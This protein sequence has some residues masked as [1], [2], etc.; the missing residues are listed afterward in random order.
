MEHNQD[1]IELIYRYIRDELTAEEQVRLQQWVNGSATNRQFFTEV[2]QPGKLFSES[3]MR[4][5]L[6]ER[7]QL[8][9]AWQKLL[10]KGLPA[11]TITTA[12]YGRK[13]K[14]FRIRF[15]LYAV[16][17]SVALFILAGVYLY[18]RPVH[19]AV[20]QTTTRPQHDVAPN[21]NQPML[22]LADG[23]VVPL[24]SNSSGTL[25][26]QGN[27][28][29][30][31]NANGDIIYS[32]ANANNPQ[33][34]EAFNSISVPKGGNVVSL[35]LADGTKVW[36]N[37]ASSIRY[38]T[39]FSGEERKV[40]MTGEAYF[41]VAHVALQKKAMPFVVQKG[42]MQVTVLGT[43][44]NVNSYDDE[45][46][47]KVTLLEGKVKVDQS[48]P[49]K[50]GGAGNQSAILKPGEQAVVTADARLTVHDN[51]DMESVMAWKNGLFV[52]DNSSTEAIMRQVQRWYNVNVVYQGD[53][54]HWTFNGQISRYSNVSKVLDLMEA[55]GTVHFK[56]EDRTIYV[57]P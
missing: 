29:I 31:R 43:H 37:A 27:V 9:Q 12:P 4:E 57:T 36:L 41:E 10:A 13:A 47:L 56:I 8:D 48:A 39:A 28:T 55:T 25:A 44:F 46:N 50:R 26:T 49:G 53:V 14:V 7:I 16:A 3:M 5:E 6:D 30:A 19:P 2:T 33:G 20:V 35:V 24:N 54:K 40:E 23:R 1:I 15:I 34:R 17:A 51:V 42:T 22:T 18:N 32:Q 38:P 21:T 11:N 45:D 52:F